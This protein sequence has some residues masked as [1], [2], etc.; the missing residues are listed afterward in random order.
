M[1]SRWASHLRS[2]RRVAGQFI[3]TAWAEHQGAPAG[4]RGEA[5]RLDAL[6]EAARLANYGQGEDVNA[7]IGAEIARRLALGAGLDLDAAQGR[8]A[9]DHEIAGLFIRARAR[10]LG[11]QAAYAELADVFTV[12]PELIRKV[13]AETPRETFEAKFPELD[14]DQIDALTR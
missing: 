5:A 13:I 12:S 4:R 8:A 6:I 10:G 14:P 7:A 11:R 2:I 9:R 1:L 3:A